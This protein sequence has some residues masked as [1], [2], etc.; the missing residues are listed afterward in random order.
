MKFTNSISILFMAM[1]LS[2]F[3]VQCSNDEGL[4]EE[5]IEDPILYSSLEDLQFEMLQNDTIQFEIPTDE[6]DTDFYFHPIVLF[7]AGEV[8]EER[9]MGQIL[10]RPIL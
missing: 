4:F 6:T 7:Q 1:V 9:V 10:F 8:E 2:L 5:N 3:I